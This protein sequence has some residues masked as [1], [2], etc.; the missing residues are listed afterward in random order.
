MSEEKW[1]CMDIHAES[2]EQLNLL[3]TEIAGLMKQSKKEGHLQR[4]FFNKY[5]NEKKKE[6]FLKVGLV[7]SNEKTLFDLDKLSKQH[8]VRVVPYDCEMWEVDGVPIDSIKCVSCELFE[9]TTEAFQKKPTLNQL[10][11]LLH[12]LM[13]Q[14]G[15]GYENELKL[16]K[17]LE[18]C[19]EQQLKG[20]HS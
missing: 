17:S 3:V 5:T 15:L 14:L 9:T 18:Q 2:Y 19:I 7:N 13:N 10:G 11:Y 4:Y 6:Y 12:F 1:K 20:N 16:Y 8:Q